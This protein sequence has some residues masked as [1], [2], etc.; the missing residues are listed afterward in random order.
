VPFDPERLALVIGATANEPTHAAVVANLAATFVVGRRP[1]T[2]LRIGPAARRRGVG[3]AEDA[4][5]GA[6]PPTR[7][8]SVAGVR[9]VEWEP[10][11]GGPSAGEVLENLQADGGVVLVDAGRVATAEFA[12]LAPLIDGVVVTCQIGRTTVENA[13]RTADSVDWSHAHLIGVVLTQ[14]PANPVERATWRRWRRSPLASRGGLAGR[15]PRRRTRD[16]D[17]PAGGREDDELGL[18]DGDGVQS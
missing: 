5:P 17:P 10:E 11:F 4:L 3:T 7:E 13:Q 6:S 9:L 2:V 15:I 18:L 16:E 1:V 12:E 14:V 8:T